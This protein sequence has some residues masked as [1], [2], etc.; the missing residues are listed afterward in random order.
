[1]RK[2]P[3]VIPYHNSKIERAI[4]SV[5]RSR[6]LVSSNLVKKFEEELAKYIGCKHVICVNSG[7]AALHLAFLAIGANREN[8]IITSSFSFIASANA[9][10]YTG[11]KPIFIDIN[12]RTY[13]IDIEKIE[14]LINEKTLAIEP[15][16]LYGQP[17]EMDKIM[18]IANKNGLIVI[19]DAAQAIGAEYDG[20]KIGSIG[21]ITCF[22]TYATKNLHTGEGGFIAT[23]ND[24]YAEKIRI[25]R[26][27]GQNGKYNHVMIGYNYRM[28]EIQAAIGII[29]LKEIDKL[30]KIRIRN[31]EYLTKRLKEI[32]GIITPYIHPKAKHVFH[33]YVIQIDEEKIGL[34]RD[35]LR[36]LLM[37]KGIETAIH[38]PKPIPLQPIYRELFNYK[39]GMFP[40]AEKISKRILSLPVNPFLKIKDLDYIANTIEKILLKN[41]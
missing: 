41:I 34:N 17:C 13:N 30:N 40:I 39:E 25:L 38:Y 15:V 28:T 11:A 22:S 2:I 21:D 27:Q 29:Q 24:E 1:M 37:N 9:I 32:D 18:E 4:I 5:L 14:E 12:E 8:E 3:L 10:V 31:A 26:D 6:K 19:E 33:Q 36:E 20:K 35:K 7:T 16:H 23:N